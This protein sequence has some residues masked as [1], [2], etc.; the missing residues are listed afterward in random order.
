M[1]YLG[2]GNLSE[3]SSRMNPCCNKWKLDSNN[4][5]FFLV[6]FLLCNLI[7]QTMMIISPFINENSSKQPIKVSGI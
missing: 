3:E 6:L 5:P 7:I 2:C 4:L 1:L